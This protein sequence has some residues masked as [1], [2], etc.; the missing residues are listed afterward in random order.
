MNREALPIKTESSLSGQSRRGFLKSFVCGLV[1]VAATAATSTAFAH[2]GHGKG[3]AGAPGAAGRVES[4][5]D[6]SPEQ[7]QQIQQTMEK[8]RVMLREQAQRKAERL[9]GPGRVPEAGWAEVVAVVAVAAAVDSVGSDIP[10]LMC[11]QRSS[12]DPEKSEFSHR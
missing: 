6:A 4:G 7:E 12:R 5:K 3:G 8:A 9:R 1:V 2:G 11:R 10:I